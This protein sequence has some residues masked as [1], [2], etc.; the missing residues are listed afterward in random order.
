MQ[1]GFK[2]L[3]G[4]TFAGYLC[5]PQS[6]KHFKNFRFLCNI[7]QAKNKLRSC[8]CSLKVVNGSQRQTDSS[9]LQIRKE[10]LTNR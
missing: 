8:R 7:Q 1:I 9:V 3:P 2:K 10:K 4:Y 6:P 5:L